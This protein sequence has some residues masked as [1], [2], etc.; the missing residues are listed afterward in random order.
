MI[1]VSNNKEKIVIKIAKK[2]QR[3]INK[4]YKTI[5]TCILFFFNQFYE[6]TGDVKTHYSAGEL[7]NNFLRQ[8]LVALLHHRLE[9]LAYT[10]ENKKPTKNTTCSKKVNEKGLCIVNSVNLHK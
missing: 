8:K 6:F 5:I 3:A 9:R 1:A 10:G 4:E 2:T 7:K